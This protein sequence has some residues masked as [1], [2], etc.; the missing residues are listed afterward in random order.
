LAAVGFAA[1]F[2]T[3]T[4]FAREGGGDLPLPN[5]PCLDG[6]RADAVPV[7]GNAADPSAGRCGRRT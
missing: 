3:S 1:A 6:D 4:G 2:S 5:K 7:A